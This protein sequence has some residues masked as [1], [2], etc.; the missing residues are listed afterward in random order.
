MKTTWRLLGLLRPHLPLVLA[1]IGLSLIALL[2]NIGLLAL[3]SWFIAA[4]AIAGFVGAVMDYTV[5]ATGVRALALLRAA[6]RYTERLVNH[7]TTL[8]I[9]SS[10]RIWFFQRIEPLAPARL[11]AIRSG[12]LLSRIRAD[13]DTLDDFYVR[14]VVPAVVAV[15]SA[16]LFIPFLARVD[17]RLVPVDLLA[18]ACGGVALPLLLKR[19]SDE[20]GRARVSLTADLRASIIEETQ[21][22]AELIALGAVGAHEE[23]MDDTLQKLDRHQRRLSS[24]QGIGEAGL[25]A[26][27]SLAAAVAA[28]ILVP[29]VVSGRLGGAGLPM[30]IVFMLASFEAVVP[31]PAV[32]QKAGEMAAAARR[33]FELI[34]AQPAVEDPARPASLP[35][36]PGTGAL[37]LTVR[38]LR[39]RYDPGERLIIDNLSFDAR[40]G[41]R[42]A[43]VGPSGAGKSTLVNI[44]MRFWEYEAGEIQVT[45]PGGRAA[46]LRS[47]GGERARSLFSVMPQSPYLFHATLKENLQVAAP[48]DQELPEAALLEAL[49]T[50]Q[51]QPLLE[52]LP[53]GM[54][55]MVGEAGKELSLGEL[56]RVALARALL[57]DAPIYLL[58]EPTESLDDMT[59]EAMLTAAAERLSGRTLIIIT[60]R[61]RDL[62]IADHV[63]RLPG[64]SRASL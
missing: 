22:M 63:L 57:R 14:G 27:A 17:A 25:A 39:F 46:D 43:I 35:G 54:D 7:D 23:V 4:M 29:V 62:A 36:A 10:I 16:A 19:H 12:D 30:L 9:L 21:G 20:P 3:S 53:G 41:S 52:Q 33:L 49:R 34:D 28:L 56:R 5:P 26:A 13:V 42:L 38:N 44:L 11:E 8:R 1:G 61:E 45:I 48:A 24:L 59:A 58:D 50:A 40:P 15:L 51:L 47:L 18:L 6:G 37:G 64:S 55:T 32:I 60:H 31:L 2:A